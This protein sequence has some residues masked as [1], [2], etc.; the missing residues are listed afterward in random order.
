MADGGYPIAAGCPHG[1]SWKEKQ[2]VAFKVL[3]ITIIVFFL[4]PRNIIY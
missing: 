1:C 2:G 3:A 4:I